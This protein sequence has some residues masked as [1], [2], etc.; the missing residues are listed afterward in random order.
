M[1]NKTD[2]CY[3]LYGFRREIAVGIPNHWIDLGSIRRIDD[4]RS[5]VRN[6]HAESAIVGS[7]RTGIAAGTS[8][9]AGDVSLGQVGDR[10]AMYRT[11]GFLI[12]IFAVL[13]SVEG[14]DLTS[15]TRGA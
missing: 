4:E 7:Q 10:K 2:S 5:E 8:T 14:A 15:R 6:V 11:I 9:A 12:L 1:I 3:L 13:R